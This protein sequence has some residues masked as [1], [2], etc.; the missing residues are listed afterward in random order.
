MTGKPGQGFRRVRRMIWASPLY[1]LVRRTGAALTRPLRRLEIAIVC[2]QDLSAHVD[3][4]EADVDLDISQASAE[5][6]DRA[7]A[8]LGRRDPHRRDLFRWRLENGCMCFVARAGSALA[9][10]D[11]FRF[12][13]GPEDGD[14][15][16]LGE[17]EVFLF[18]VYVDENW[19]GHRI[20]SAIGTRLRFFAN[21]RGTPQPTP[22]LA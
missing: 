8:G 4:F 14:M 6:V 20:Q 18:D 13:P 7:A 9:A 2:R 17:R 19:R 21:S 16:A 22:K 12:R 15:I 5:E 11:W 10:Y 1:R 3:V